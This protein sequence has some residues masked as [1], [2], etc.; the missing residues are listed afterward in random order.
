MTGI[1]HPGLPEPPD[2]T[3]NLRYVKLGVRMEAPR[4]AAELGRDRCGDRTGGS[5]RRPLGKLRG[6]GPGRRHGSSSPLLRLEDTVDRRPPPVLG[7]V[8]PCAAGSGCFH[9]PRW[10]RFGRSWPDRLGP[11]LAGRAGDRRTLAGVPGAAPAHQSPRS[12]RR[13]GPG[14]RLEGPQ[15]RAAPPPS[16]G[17]RWPA[18]EA[19]RPRPQLCCLE[20]PQRRVSAQVSRF[21]LRID[22]QRRRRG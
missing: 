8:A 4:T 14:D 7:R 5:G 12:G 10:P 11:D 3:H 22:P 13:R 9:G 20:A 6:D 15:R 1:R 17:Q 18:V 21:Q 19:F 16:W 2:G